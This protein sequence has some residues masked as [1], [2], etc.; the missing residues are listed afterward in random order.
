MACEVI[1]FSVKK[2]S[3]LSFTSASMLCAIENV[4]GHSAALASCGSHLSRSRLI[5]SADGKQ[6]MVKVLFD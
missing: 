3:S 6:E 5:V 2:Q 4:A 1:I